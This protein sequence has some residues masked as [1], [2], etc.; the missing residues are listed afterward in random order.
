[1]FTFSSSLAD[2]HM[3]FPLMFGVAY[4]TN[5]YFWIY[6]IMGTIYLT[7]MSNTN[8]A[9]F[10]VEN[11]LNRHF[12]SYHGGWFRLQFWLVL[13]LLQYYFSEFRRVLLEQFN[14][15]FLTI[16][17]LLGIGKSQRKV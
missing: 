13:F 4:A 10:V 11:I 2:Q 8:V 5:F 9:P 3:I 16:L 1:M 14:N 7:L 12:T 6:T 17:H 15:Y